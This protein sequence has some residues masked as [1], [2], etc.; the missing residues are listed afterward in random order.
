MRIKA[1]WEKGYKLIDKSLERKSF[2]ERCFSIRTLITVLIILLIVHLTLKLYITKFKSLIFYQYDLPENEIYEPSEIIYQNNSISEIDTNELKTI[3]NFIKSE[4][5]LNPD[6]TFQKYEDPKIS[7]II[8]IYN[9]EKLIENSLYSIYN[10]NFKEIEIIIIDDYS[11]DKT[12]EKISQLISKFHSISFYLN[13][14]NK[15][16]LYSKIQGILK[17]KGKYILFLYPGDF[18]T[19]NDVFTTLYG[20]AEKDN[21]DILGFSSLLNNGK[22]LHHYNDIDMIKT[23]IISQLIYNDTKDDFHRVGD[24]IFNYFIKSELLKNIVNEINDDFFV[25]K[26]IRYNSDFYLLFLMGKNATN[27]RQIKNIFYYSSKNW[28][29]K[30]KENELD[31]RCSNYINYLDFLYNKTNDFYTEKKIVLHELQN[32]ILN[33]RCRKNEFIRDQATNLVKLISEKRYVPNKYKRDLFIY[34]FEN[35]TVIS[36]L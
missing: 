6:E 19:K 34:M 23:N 36:N 1:R 5:L 26:N 9:G 3:K 11:T 4:K 13:E 22:Y 14:K 30:W 20:Q 32:W 27:F 17:S 21:L 18:F 2:F 8:P 10:Q 33:T 25:D 24:V 35:V 28:E 29:E 31:M 12:S 16:M 7:I 15:G